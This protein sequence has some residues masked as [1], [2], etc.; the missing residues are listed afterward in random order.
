MLLAPAVG[1]KIAKQ[2]IKH[3]TQK[4]HPVQTPALRPF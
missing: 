3:A 2:K 4:Q 1:V